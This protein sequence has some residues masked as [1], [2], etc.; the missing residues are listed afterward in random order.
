MGILIQVHDDR[1]EYLSENIEDGLR[2]L[3]NAMRCISEMKDMNG[4]ANQRDKA[5]YGERR[6]Y[7]RHGIQ[8]EETA[9]HVDPMYM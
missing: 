9:S 7:G 6:E 2:A 4:K 3:G 5:G 1:L 8:M